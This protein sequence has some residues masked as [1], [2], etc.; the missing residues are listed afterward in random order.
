MF[1][2]SPSITSTVRP[3]VRPHPAML[4]LVLLPLSGAACSDRLLRESVLA[5]TQS[6][7]GLSLGQNPRTG[8]YEGTLGYARGEL[9]LVPTGK[10]VV[11]ASGEAG[12]SDPAAAAAMTSDH[13][14]TT[15]EVLGEIMADGAF[16]LDA[17]RPGGAAGPPVRVGVYQRLAVGRLAVSTPAAIALM[18]R[19]G[20]ATPAAQARE[21]DRTLDD[22]A[23]QSAGVLFP[24]GDGAPGR[25]SVP[26]TVAADAWSRELGFAGYD[27][28]YAT[29]SPGVQRALAARWSAE[30]NLA[31]LLTRGAPREGAPGTISTPAR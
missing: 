7:I 30:L 10:R 29:G 18:A 1:R 9:F 12:N 5:S 11:N 14:D 24:V 13:A 2:A 8:L 17:G 28:L 19:D 22:L 25:Q 6:T 23:A 20:L 27:A 21:A 31:R 26:W 15:P 4:A 16:P 3:A